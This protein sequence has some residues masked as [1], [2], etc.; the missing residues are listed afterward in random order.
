MDLSGPGIDVKLKEKERKEERGMGYI[1]SFF[2]FHVC[3]FLGSFTLKMGGVGCGAFFIKNLIFV[4]NF[5]D[6]L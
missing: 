3:N 2:Y 4:V 6:R 5:F 1:S